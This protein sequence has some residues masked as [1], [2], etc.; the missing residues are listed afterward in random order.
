VTFES[1]SELADLKRALGAQLAASRRAVEIGQQQVA[2]KTGYSRS[3]VAHAEAG[4]QLLSREFWKT[5]D[6]LLKAEGAL[7]A[8]YERVHAFQ[9]E[10]QRRSRETELVGALA[11]AGGFREGDAESLSLPCPS[12]LPSSDAMVASSQRAWRVVRSYLVRHRTR[13]AKRVVG[14][15]TL[16]GGWRMCLPWCCRVG[17]P[18][19]LCRS[20]R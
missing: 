12:S 2:H 7:L 8:G 1:A 14:C 9:Q 17:C 11:I 15:T 3:S 10:Q 13:L 6:E 4:R 16:R 20:R 19:V 5:A 18:A